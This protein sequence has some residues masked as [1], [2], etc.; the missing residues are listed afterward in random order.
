[1]Q[2]IQVKKRWQ[3]SKLL[4]GTWLSLRLNLVKRPSCRRLPKIEKQL[5]GQ[6]LSVKRS[7]MM[8]R[9]QARIFSMKNKCAKMLSVN[10]RR[11]S[12]LKRKKPRWKANLLI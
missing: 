12:V 5:S 1:M 11:G 2:T 9:W 10:N 3:M 6:N 7:F 8:N 4:T